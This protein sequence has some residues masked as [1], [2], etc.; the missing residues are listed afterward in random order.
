MNG[1]S[2]LSLLKVEDENEA[3]DNICNYNNCQIY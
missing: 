1:I 3:K 2:N